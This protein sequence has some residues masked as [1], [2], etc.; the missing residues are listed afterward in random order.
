MP[1]ATLAMMKSTIRTTSAPTQ[2]NAPPGR[3]KRGRRRNWK[4]PGG[5]PRPASSSGGW[6]RNAMTRCSDGTT[7]ALPRTNKGRPCGRPLGRVAGDTGLRVLDD[8]QE[9]WDELWLAVVDRGCLQG[10]Q[11]LLELRLA[12][13]L[14]PL[15]P[16]LHR[17]AQSEDKRLAQ[18]LVAAQVGGEH[19]LAA[20]QPGVDAGEVLRLVAGVVLDV[21]GPIGQV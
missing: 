4:S 10:A 2:R 7:H 18:R 9:R 14:K 5:G 15:F 19:R 11:V 17:I 20:A 8:V 3:R 13:L 6:N 12:E 1:L 16:L 21:V